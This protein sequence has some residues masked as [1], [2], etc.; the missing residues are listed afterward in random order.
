MNISVAMCTF[1]GERYLREQ[2]E[3]LT[4]QTRLPDELV[5][6]D[7]CSTDQTLPIVKEFAASAP[8]P[9][10]V[11]VNERNLGYILNF[12]QAIRMCNGDV[13]ALSDQDDVWLPRKLAILETKFVED[14]EVGL[15]FSDA[16]VVREDSSPAG[17]SLWEKLGVTRA[18][19][20]RVSSGRNF[21][22]LLQGATVTGATMAF[23]SRFRPLVLPLPHELPLIHDAWIT[24]L[25][26]AVTRV[27]PVNEKLIRYRQHAS[28]QVGALERK[29]IK[30]SRPFA[31]GS[32]KEALGRENAY[33][34]ALAV[35]RAAHQRLTEKAPEFDSAQIAPTLVSQIAHLE[36]RSRLPR[37]PLKRTTR[38][39]A[40]LLAG[41]YHRFGSGA[42]S[43][44]KDLFS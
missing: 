16:E 2:L 42:R 13:I 35:A 40:E 20:Q 32:A 3:S 33:S 6:C 7:D 24:L 44:I 17:Y 18:E 30:G 8:F 37:G 36:L 29:G 28:Q 4:T 19:L 31:P 38:V 25:V 41:R 9:V 1:N 12:E 14:P 21:H 34:Q 43:A 15:V 10:V 5:I 26:A 11:H 27:L 39:L 22:S 23:R